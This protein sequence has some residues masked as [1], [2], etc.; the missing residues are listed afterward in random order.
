MRLTYSGKRR[1]DGVEMQIPNTSVRRCAAYSSSNNLWAAFN[2][3]LT[4][5]NCELISENSYAN[6]SFVD[7]PNYNYYYQQNMLNPCDSSPCLYGGTCLSSSD[8]LNYTC[9][10]TEPQSG[11]N[12]EDVICD[13]TCFRLNDV[14]YYIYSNV[15]SSWTDAE[16]YCISKEQEMVMIKTKD[17]QESIERNLK[18]LYADDGGPYNKAYWIGLSRA[19]STSIFGWWDCTPLGD[20]NAW[21]DSSDQNQGDCVC[22]IRDSSNNYRWLSLS[23]NGEN[24]DTWDYMPICQENYTRCDDYETTTLVDTT[25]V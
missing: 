22:L 11:K 12:C 18:T 14:I 15:T 23:C 9:N 16:S 3:E 19:N 5:G 7:D 21:V 24:T 13:T 17:I 1:T 2:F 6:S 4:T 20:W 8:N 10:C 25:I